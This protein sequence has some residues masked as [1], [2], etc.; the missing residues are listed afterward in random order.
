V[1][2]NNVAEWKAI[3]AKVT[4]A[5]LNWDRLHLEMFQLLLL[6][7]RA[8][9]PAIRFAYWPR[10]RPRSFLCAGAV[11]RSSCG[12]CDRSLGAG[13]ARRGSTAVAASVAKERYGN[14]LMKRTGQAL[15]TPDRP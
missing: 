13:C 7:R 4:E 12:T 8:S 1:I 14:Y 9:S 3:E 11:G 15:L 5:M 6:E 10:L 2:H